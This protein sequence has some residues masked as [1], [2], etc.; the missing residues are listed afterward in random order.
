MKRLDIIMNSYYTDEEK[1]TSNHFKK[2]ELF[3]DTRGLH[4]TFK[5][6]GQEEKKPSRHTNAGASSPVR[7]IFGL[8]DQ[9]IKARRAAR[10][11]HQENSFA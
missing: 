1:D 4:C 6:D 9:Q 11:F 5:A 10:S 2:G 8:A 3:T 7:M